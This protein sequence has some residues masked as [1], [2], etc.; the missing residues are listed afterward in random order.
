MYTLAPLVACLAPLLWFRQAPEGSPDEPQLAA[1][2]LQ[3]EDPAAGAG[4]VAVQELHPLLTL[5]HIYQSAPDLS[6]LAV[7]APYL[8]SY[9]VL[10]LRGGRA[11]TVAGAPE[12]NSAGALF[13]AYLDRTR[14]AAVAKVLAAF[15]SRKKLAG[16][17]R[18]IMADVKLT[19]QSGE[20]RR[21]VIKQGRFVGLALRSAGTR[22]VALSITGLG[23]QFS[24]LNP[25]FRLYLYHSSQPTEPLATYEVPRTSRVYFEW[26][27]L[28]ITLPA[29][30]T[31]GEYRLGY[32][33]DDLVGQAVDLQHDF[34]SRPGTG[35]CCG[36]D[37]L[38]FDAYAPHV[39]VRAFTATAEAG[40]DVLPGDGK[41]TYVTGSNFGLNLQLSAVCDLSDYFCRYRGLFLEALQLQLA[42]D[43]LNQMAYSTRNNGVKQD[44][45]ALALVALNNRPDAQP[46]LLSQLDAALGALD[47]DLSGVSTTCLPCTKPKGNRV[48]A[49]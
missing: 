30:P 19:G 11:P 13:S 39:Q 24:D 45:Q 22:D 2:L 9:P 21:K 23:T 28:A 17:G 3:P 15:T 20:Y 40:T 42:V 49:I 32:F 34:S 48:G 14:T 29:G 16:A 27:P 5:R 41:P 33:E 46:G 35:G 1:G 18:T 38:L 25:S 12:P 37:Y 43:L 8:G 36:S 7:G 44:V 26:T 47:V 31:G 4:P 6:A 10:Q